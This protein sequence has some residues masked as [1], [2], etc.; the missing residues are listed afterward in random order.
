MHSPSKVCIFLLLTSTFDFNKLRVYSRRFI[1]RRKMQITFQH[2]TKETRFAL[3]ILCDSGSRPRC[4]P[5]QKVKIGSSDDNGCGSKQPGESLT[6][7]L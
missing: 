1:S 2:R 4:S 5:E 3:E 6:Y 7:L